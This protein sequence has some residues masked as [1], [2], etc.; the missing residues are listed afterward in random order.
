MENDISPRWIKEI[1]AAF[2]LGALSG[3]L[4][5]VILGIFLKG[6]KWTL[7]LS[8]LMPAMIISGLL[9]VLYRYQ[10]EKDDMLS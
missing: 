8:L 5:T 6:E 2:I 7:F 10:K 4:I 9:I 1:I 3:K